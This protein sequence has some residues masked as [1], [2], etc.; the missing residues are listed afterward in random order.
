M[1]RGG[2][3]PCRIAR[4]NRLCAGTVKLSGADSHS[5]GLVGIRCCCRG[6]VI[7]REQTPGAVEDAGEFDPC[8]KEVFAALDYLQAQS[9][10][11]WG[12]T[13][14]RKGWSRIRLRRYEGDLLSSGSVLVSSWGA[15]KKSERP[16][17]GV[18][19]GCAVPEI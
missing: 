11:S 14:L 3:D 7:R 19:N 9:T 1:T 4:R 2:G 8:T 15:R 18:R 6:W 5:N 10:R 13:V 17:T 12:F 16:R